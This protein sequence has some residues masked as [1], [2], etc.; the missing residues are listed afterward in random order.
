MSEGLS[1]K[2]L[3]IWP[4]FT[5]QTQKITITSVTRCKKTAHRQC[6]CESQESMALFFVPYEDG[7]LSS[8]LTASNDLIGRVR[9]VIAPKGPGVYTSIG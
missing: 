1:R 4:A 7:G 8:P 5:V 3:H 6:G 9:E 2:P